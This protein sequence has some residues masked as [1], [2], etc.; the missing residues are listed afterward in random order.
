MKS[1]RQKT[2]F[3]VTLDTHGR[4]QFETFLKANNNSFDLPLPMITQNGNKENEV[5]TQGFNL[6][7]RCQSTSSFNYKMKVTA[8]LQTKSSVT[9]IASR[10][11]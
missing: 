5:K 2:D 8:K 3:P 1:L 7:L 11:N 9:T 10:V 6:G 4:L